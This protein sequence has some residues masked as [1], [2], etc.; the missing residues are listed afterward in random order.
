MAIGQGRFQKEFFLQMGKHLLLGLSVCAVIMFFAGLVVVHAQGKE[1]P[2]RI[3]ILTDY[4]GS[5]AD[6]GP[7][8]RIVQ[9]LFM[10]EIGYK[11]AG[12][13]IKLFNEDSGSNP[14]MGLEK[15]RKLVGVDKVHILVGTALGTITLTVAKYA[16]EVKIPFIAW[17]AGHYEAVET[18][19]SFAPGPPPEASSYIAGLY[20]YDKGYRTAISIGQDYVAGHKLNGGAMQAFLDKGGQIIQKQWVPLGTKD[21][22]PYI[23][24]MKQANVCFFWFAGVTTFTFLKQYADFGFL[25]KMP[26]VMTE[27]DTLFDVWLKE[28]DPRSVGRVSGRTSY[29]SDIDIPVNK[30][31]VAAFRAKTG[32]DPDAYDE[33][34]YEA[35][36]IAI[37]AFERTNGDTNPEKLR[38]A[39]R[40]QELATPAGTL[41]ISPEGYAFRTSYTF[42]LAQKDGRIVRKRIGQYAPQQL[43]R[44]R[45][46][47]AP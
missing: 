44:L 23:T 19:W 7:K 8:W 32:T 30:K 4:S 3:G 27:G 39:I 5:I 16:A 15:A 12:K 9:D 35:M 10:E 25:T 1:E 22:A 2:I 20:A 17:R 28:V 6:Y 42:D 21:F 46:G 13:P 26:L 40:G 36:M 34:A 37:K 31:F 38:N 33:G 24:A 18:G 43:I 41:K 14:T 45:P 47:I 29:T 11:V